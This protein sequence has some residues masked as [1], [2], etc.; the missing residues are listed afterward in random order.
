MLCVIPAHVEST[1]LPGKPLLK[2]TGKTLVQHVW[3]NADQLEIDRLVV[4]TSSRDVQKEVEN[5]GGEVVLTPKFATG[6]DRVAHVAKR[7]LS[8]TVINFQCD[9][10]E[11]DVSVLEKALETC[12]CED[13]GVITF[14]TDLPEEGREDR[15][16]VKV[17]TDFSD[18]AIYFSRTYLE[19]AYLHLGVYVYRRDVLLKFGISS[20]SSLELMENLEQLR[21]LEYMPE[22]KI[23]CVYVSTKCYGIN[24][25]KDY[26]AFVQR[27]R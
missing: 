21:I 4:A 14:I 22:V 10:P 1:R 7:D 18:N 27:Q 19:G 3:E 9:E 5:F 11:F 15:N 13:V 17:V 12:Y 24:T 25:R 26:D 2:E 16:L 23:K 8:D 6:S 20:W